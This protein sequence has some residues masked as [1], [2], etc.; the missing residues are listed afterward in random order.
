M[1]NSFQIYCYQT[2]NDTQDYIQKYN[3]TVIVIFA[4]ADG[5]KETVG[6]DIQQRIRE[7]LTRSN[8]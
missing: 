3:V 6:D 4:P 7:N 5:N 8:Y 1:R 2:L